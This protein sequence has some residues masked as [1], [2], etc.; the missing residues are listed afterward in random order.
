MMFLAVV[1]VA[2]ASPAASPQNAARQFHEI[3]SQMR[4]AH[5]RGDWVAF[6]TDARGLVQFLNG[7]PDALVELARADVHTGDPHGALDNLQKF[8]GM[9]QSLDV[10][11]TLPD[12]E[13]LHAQ[14]RFQRFLQTM[15]ANVRPLSHAERALV[16]PEP[17]LL[18]EDVD[19]D[20]GSQ[21]FFLTSVLEKKIVTLDSQGRLADFAPAPDSWPM[22]GLKVDTKHGVVLAT[23]VA[24][25]GFTSVPKRD[26]GRSAVVLYDLKTGTLLRRIEGPRPSAFG[27]LALSP[28]GDALV[29]DGEG[30]GVYAIRRESG[31]MERVDDGQFI[32]P[33]TPGY[34][35]DGNHAFVPDY[36]RGIGVLDLV[37]KSV[38]WIP[39]DDRFALEGIDGLY[40]SGNE[41]VA[42]QNGT[43]PERVIAFT[44]DTA[45]DR[46][47]S[48]RSI[49][50]ATP[51]LDPT[52]GALVGD[53]FYYIANSG[54]NQLANDGT[55]KKGASLTPAR[56]MRSQVPH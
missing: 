3:Q 24:L 29:S 36:V 2:A 30:G 10:L 37:A 55:V 14:S 4:Q 12:F 35:S 31:V 38:R 21:R 25:D 44:L 49:E 9:G 19:Y 53:W 15:D 47:V 1:L 5:K 26:W 52:H 27:D 56:I 43:S 18:P 39:M 51:A 46:V 40:V 22:L 20:A 32:S 16:I 6:R 7:S 17:G 48:E 50:S 54:W 11:R 13:A 8:A 42:V 41:L 34:I 33:Q 23:E 45:M 28:N